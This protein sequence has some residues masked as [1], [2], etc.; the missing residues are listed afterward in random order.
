[1]V[2]DT[3]EPLQEMPLVSLVARRLPSGGSDCGGG[4]IGPWRRFWEGFR[5]F[6][7]P[8]LRI[9]FA[10]SASLVQVICNRDIS[11]LLRFP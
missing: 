8:P 1:M 4:M 11:T 10:R 3:V 2:L 9:R 6:P 7:G 5:F